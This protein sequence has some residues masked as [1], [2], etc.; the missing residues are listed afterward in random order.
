MDLHKYIDVDSDDDAYGKPRPT[1]DR[2]KSF[3]SLLKLS[4]AVGGRNHTLT[5]PEPDSEF[6]I[7]YVHEE[8]IDISADILRTHIL[9]SRIGKLVR[10]K[11]D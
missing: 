7:P 6:L 11:I 2:K 5:F 3:D 10:C 4:Q 1:P 9:R 8:L